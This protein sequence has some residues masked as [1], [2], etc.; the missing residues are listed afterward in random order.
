MSY[1][2]NFNEKRPMSKIEELEEY[3]RRKN[4]GLASAI[5]TAVVAVGSMVI[6]NNPEIT[7]ETLKISAEI[8]KDILP[9]LGLLFSVD[10]A[11]FVVNQRRFNEVVNQL[12]L[13]KGIKK[14]EPTPEKTE[15]MERK[16]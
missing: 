15:D 6:S 9:Y 3:R 1:Q 13:K 10:T 2:E 7:N 4:L 11:S 12:G 5:G 14:S 16:R 8:V